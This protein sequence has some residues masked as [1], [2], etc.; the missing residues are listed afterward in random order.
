MYSNMLN[1]VGAAAKVFEYL[2]REPLVSTKGALEPDH[3]T[4]H[5][6]FQNLTFSYPSRPDAP[7]LKVPVSFNVV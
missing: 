3:L 7:T 2:D 1:S 4:G 5:V 6:Q